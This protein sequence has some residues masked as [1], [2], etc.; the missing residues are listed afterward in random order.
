[1]T[2]LEN[3]SLDILDNAQLVEATQY[4]I[5]CWAE[6]DAVDGVGYA[7]PNYMTQDMTLQ[8]ADMRF[9]QRTCM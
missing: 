9:V 7:A 4:D 1:M 2:Q 3:R 5:Y 6:D 8:P